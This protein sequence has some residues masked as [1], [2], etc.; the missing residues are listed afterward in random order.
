MAR[1]PFREGR[2]YVGRLQGVRER[3]IENSKSSGFRLLRLEF[4]IFDLLDS[5]HTLTSTGHIACRDIIAGPGVD[6]TRDASIAAYA[7]ALRLRNASRVSQWLEL[8]GGMIWVSITFGGLGP[9]DLRNTFKAIFPFDAE[10]WTVREY[11]RSLDKESVS[12]SEAAD[13]LGCSEN[14]IRR[15]LKQLELEWGEKLVWRSGGNHRRIRLALLRNL[16]QS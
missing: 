10:S 7:G 9:L 8:P 14:T 3:P 13:D 16:W 6:A 5:Q 1:Y 11:G 15:K 2:K 4:E 12:V